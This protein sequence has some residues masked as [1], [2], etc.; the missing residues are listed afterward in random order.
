MMVLG[1]TPRGVVTLLL[2]SAATALVSPASGACLPPPAGLVGWWAGDGNA[3]D[4]AGTNNGSLQGGATATAAGMVAQ[5]FSFDGTNSYVQIPDAPALKPTNLTVEAWVNFTGLDSARSGTAPAGDQYIV[6][7]Q[8]AQAYYFEG[9]SLEKFRIANGDA[10]MFTVGSA[11]GQEV[12]LLSKTLV[13]TSVWYHVA[14]VRGSNF[15]QLYVNG[16]LES[17]TNVSFAQNYGTLPLYFGASHETYWDGKLKGRLDEVSLYNRALSSNEVAAVYAAGA[18]GKCKAAS[19]PTITTQPQS[20][21]V[22]AGGNVVFTVTAAGSG[23]GYQWQFNGGAIADATNANLT[24]ANV[25]PA[26]AGS[27][28]V[29][30]SNSTASVSSVVAVLTVLLPPV[31]TGQPQSLTNVTG[32]TASFSATATG[33]APL[34]YQWQLNGVGLA[35]GGRVSG[36]NTSAVIVTNVQ[37]ADAGNYTLVVSNAVGVVTSAI[38]VLTV[39][40]PPVITAQ[41]ANQGVVA[42]A[43]AN[44]AVTAS[45]TPPLVYQWVF[46]N[47]A[48]P[49]A[50]NTTLTITNVQ[51]TDAG[52]YS[53]LVMNPVGAVTSA[54]AVLTVLVPP[55]I[56][57]QPQG[58]TNLTGTAAAFS[59]TATGSDPLGYQWQLNGVTLANGG[60]FS[61]ARTNTLSITNVQ[62]SDAGSY[63][64]VVSNAAGV[65]TSAVATLSVIAPPT[66]TTQPV[67][68]SVASGSNASFSV[69]VSGTLPLSYQ[70]LVN[71]SNLTDGSQFSGSASPTLVVLNAQTTN[72]GGYSVLVTNV[73][74]SVT[75]AVAV[76]TVNVAGSCLPPPTGL[77]GWWPGDGNAKDT[78]STNNGTLQ[79]GA[80]ATAAGMVAQAFSFDGTNN[81]VQIPDAPALK[82]TN[83]TIEAW[84]NFSSLNSAL[85]G[86]APAGD[87]YLVFKQNSQAYY[88]EGY[89]LEKF[90]VANGDAFM[91][92]VGSGSGL[93]VTILSATL[94]KTSV[95]YHVAAVRGSNF[96]QL[97]VN[98]QL[99]RQTNV[100]FAQNYGTLPL[101]FGTSGETYWD[102][103]LKG[104]LDEV[105]L[106]N[107]ALSSN[108]VA[109]IYAA[110]AAGKCKVVTGLT[111]TTQPQSQTIAA[112]SSATVSVGAA[113]TAPLGYQW[114]FNGTN[115]SGATTSTLTLVGVQPAD[116]GSYLAIV[117]NPTASVT[118]AVALLT[119]L[120]PPAITAQ[121]QSVTN[122]SGTTANFSATASG[123]APLNYHWQLN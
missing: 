93:E 28:M 52:G 86:T 39:T 20:Q 65:V 43:N 24:L 103:K 22:A 25:Q 107:R 46:G 23:L 88:F 73:A 123:S 55:L 8:N 113:G 62:L 115:L 16:Q 67:G 106:Y 58:L 19:G 59:A 85:S 17:Q 74:G 3:N 6:F 32:T 69:T 50:T 118:S 94:V 122:L 99:E 7:K 48:I 56:T 44:F 121:P 61:G 71:G 10:F 63:T 84:V 114:Q 51:P 5:G 29:V 111:I 36:A 42:G 11:S 81:Y 72:A 80:T 66:I 120:L 37:A 105:S 54:V 116:A 1:R 31:I 26:N 14:A 95:W 90:R 87:Q 102:G 40:G 104:I 27:Y 64:L 96:M 60:R 98:G 57:A 33:S 34:G 77:V 45:G 2:M 15:M 117:T 75:S 41:P 70:W 76:L 53:V 112:G 21:S 82:P 47:A 89:S 101:Y 4:I 38:A 100:T 119:V 78:T 13:K 35:N 30:V 68:Q 83:L 9:Y 79:G 18:S 110:G 109:A 97:Y 92:T 91:F 49:G 12:A 108:E